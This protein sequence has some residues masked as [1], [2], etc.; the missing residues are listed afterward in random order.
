MMAAH[1]VADATAKQVALLQAAVRSSLENNAGKIVAR[2]GN[3]ATS[4]AT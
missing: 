4:M 2:V 1:G 3:G